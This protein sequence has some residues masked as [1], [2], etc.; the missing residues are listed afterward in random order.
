[1]FNG[2]LVS[3]M[4]VEKGQLILVGGSEKMKAGCP[5]DVCT[6]DLEYKVWEYGQRARMIMLLLLTLTSGREG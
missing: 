1:M 5:T 2:V 3:C 6:K 4:S